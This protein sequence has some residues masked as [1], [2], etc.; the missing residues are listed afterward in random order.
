MSKEVESVLV[1]TFIKAHSTVTPVN[2][3]IFDYIQCYMVFSK[4]DLCSVVPVMVT[5]WTGPKEQKQN[6]LQIMFIFVQT[7][8]RN[9][10][11]PKQAPEERVCQTLRLCRQRETKAC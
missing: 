11:K 10:E 7:Q 9:R 2:L 8:Q 1:A 4:F 5:E 6:F 3:F